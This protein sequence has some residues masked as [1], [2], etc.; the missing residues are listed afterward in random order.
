MNMYYKKTDRPAI[1]NI[2]K[3]D[4]HLAK[5]LD[6][7]DRINTT[8]ERESFITLKLKDNKENFKKQNDMATNKPLQTRNRQN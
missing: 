8:A 7:A 2:T 1:N 6:L 4:I 3:T 5:N